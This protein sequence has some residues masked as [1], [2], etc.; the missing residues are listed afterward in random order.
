MRAEGRDLPVV[1]GQ[2]GSLEAGL[3]AQEGRRL[4]HAVPP[5]LEAPLVRAAAEQTHV[6]RERQ[7]GQDQRGAG[8]AQRKVRK[9]TDNG[10]DVN[11]YSD[12][13]KPL[14]AFMTLCRRRERSKHLDNFSFYLF[15]GVFLHC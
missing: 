4:V 12:N 10:C 11:K 6:L 9:E 7:R 13:T 5:K 8:H 2:T 3:A 14:V 1:S 15:R